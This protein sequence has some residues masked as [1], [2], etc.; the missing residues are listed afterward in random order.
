MIHRFQVQPADVCHFG[1]RMRAHE[2]GRNSWISISIVTIL[3]LSGFMPLID[4]GLAFQSD[5]SGQDPLGF[6]AST[7]GNHTSALTNGFVIPA[8][9]TITDGWMNVSNDWNSDG[10]NGTWFESGVVN[11]SLDMGKNDFTSTSHF[12]GSISLAPDRNV[13][14]VDDFEDLNLQF[15]GFTASSD[16]WMVSDLNL[17][18]ANG[19]LPNSV[20][21]GI[22]FAGATQ[23]GG[24]HPG[25]NE[26]LLIEFITLPQVINN[27]SLHFEHWLA[28]D[29]NDGAWV[30][31]RLDNGSWNNIEPINGH[32]QTLENGTPA[33]VGL[34]A[35]AWSSVEYSLEQE[36]GL[37]ELQNASSISF[38][39]HISTAQNSMERPGWFIDAINLSNTG[40]PTNS[41]FHGNLNGAYAANADGAITISANTTGM[42]SPM[43]LEFWVDWD[44]EGNNND[45]LVVEASLDGTNWSLISAPPG[46]PGSGVYID[47]VWIYSESNG[48]KQ[49]M[50]P[51]PNSFTNKS[52][53]WFR[54][55]VY[56]DGQVNGGYGISGWE[57][58]Y[59]DDPTLHSNIQAPNHQKLLLD[60]F[61]S[62]NSVS[63]FSPS[64]SVQQWQHV[65]NHGHNGPTWSAFG[66]EDSPLWPDGW[67]VKIDFG[68]RGWGFGQYPG[69]GPMTGFTSGSNGAGIEFS[70]KYLPDMWTH[71]ITPEMHIPEE[72]SARLAFQHWMCAEP[73][74]DGGTVYVSTDDG[75][76]WSHFGQNSNNFYDTNSTVN[77]NSPLY[78]KGIFDGSLVTSG[79]FNAHPFTLKKADVSHLA[80]EDVRFRFSFFSDQYVEEWGWYLDDVGIEV[81]YFETQG[82]WTSPPIYADEWGYGLL[83]IRGS[84]P[85]GTSVTASVLD[86]NEQYLFENLS[87]P[88]N[89]QNINWSAYPSIKVRLNLHTTDPYL[90]P[91]IDKISIGSNLHL[92]KNT[93]NSAWSNGSEYGYNEPANWHIRNNRWEAGGSGSSYLGY[94]FFEHR[95]IKELRLNCVC[96]GV[97]VNIGGQSQLVN[98]PTTIIQTRNA[99]MG[100]VLV[101]LIINQNGWIESF[102]MHAK[103][104]GI[105]NHSAIDIGNDGVDSDKGW[106]ENEPEWAWPNDSIYPISHYGLQSEISHVEVVKEGLSSRIDINSHS[107]SMIVE[108]STLNISSYIPNDAEVISYQFIFDAVYLG[109]DSNNSSF[110]HDWDG[111]YIGSGGG[112]NS[113]INDWNMQMFGE[114]TNF[115]IPQIIEFQEF[116]YLF[117]FTGLWKLDVH[118][119]MFTYDLKENISLDEDDLS[120]ILAEQSLIQNSTQIEIPVNYSSYGGAVSVDGAII[121]QYMITNSVIETPE[122]MVPDGSIYRTIT[123]HK[124]LRGDEFTSV[125]LMLSP[126]RSIDSAEVLMRIVN[127]QSSEPSFEQPLGQGLIDWDYSNTT[128]TQ[129]EDGWI[130]EW[131]WSTLWL[132][133]DRARLH[134]L[135]EAHDAAGT[136]LGP[137]VKTTGFSAGNAV[138]NDLELVNIVVKDRFGRVISDILDPEYP[139]PVAA[140]SNIE[141]EG[142]VRFEGSVDSWIPMGDTKIELLLVQGNF[143]NST[144]LEVG[145]EGRWQYNLNIPEAN[146]D[147]SYNIPIKLEAYLYDAGPKNIPEGLVEDTTTG[148]RGAEFIWDNGGPILGTLYAM[149]P[150]GDQPADGHIWNKNIPLALGIEISD[151]SALGDELNLHY[152]RQSLDDDDDDGNA[153][154]S[155]YNKLTI[156]L[157]K[158]VSEYIEFPFIEVGDV[159]ENSVIS[160]YVS[161]EDLAGIPVYG[162]GNY[163]L[164]ADLATII[165]MQDTPTEVV[166]F[167]LEM[168]LYDGQIIPSQ[169]HVF[170][171]AIEDSNGLNSLDSIFFSLTGNSDI[172]SIEYLPWSN[173]PI[174]W[175]EECF[176]TEPLVIVEDAHPRYSVQFNFK[177]KWSSIEQLGEEKYI[178][179]FRIE[180]LGTDLGLGLTNLVWLEWTLLTQLEVNIISLVDLVPKSGSLLENTL[181]LTP[182]DVI[183]LEWNLRYAGTNIT[184]SEL[185]EGTM[186]NAKILGGLSEM[187]AEVNL[188]NNQT[189]ITRFAFKSDDFPNHRGNLIIAI[190]GMEEY[191][192]EDLEVSV[193]LDDDSPRV[194][195]HSTSLL[196][197][198]SDSLD[199]IQVSFSIID[200]NGMKPGPLSLHWQF[201]RNGLAIT[202]AAGV[203]QVDHISGEIYNDILN[204]SEALKQVE[205]RG[206]DDLI[207]W[208]EGEDLSGNS[209]AGP[210]SKIE[211]R[212][213]VWD[214]IKFEPQVTYISVNP[215][216]P[217]LGEIITIDVQV[218]NT[219]TLEGNFSLKL[220]QLIDGELIEI[221][222]TK[223]Y[224]LLPGLSAQFTFEYEIAA[225]G[226]Q[227]LYIEIEGEDGLTPIPLGIVRDSL[228]EDNAADQQMIWA[229]GGLVI[230][231]CTFTIFML[232]R[233]QLHSENDEYDDIVW[234]DESKSGRNIVNLAS[235]KQ[236][237]SLEI[238]PPRPPELDMIHE[239]E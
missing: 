67:D 13:G 178:P 29:E 95:P 5:Y 176:Q 16:I 197:I 1:V 192:I 96:S 199:D 45:N 124:H 47:G 239:E 226:D 7:E 190:T 194:S 146:A 91:V 133:D 115:T 87:L 92:T 204:L 158:G 227:Q 86:I 33:F 109:T 8:N 38:R 98:S 110:Q 48:F 229:L 69:H 181:Y 129:T 26:W 222:T 120:I 105:A 114:R 15:R 174:I 200:D 182:G 219:G 145:E 89:L 177:L 73:N 215:R 159:L 203:L 198:R 137:A 123:K 3:L 46:I 57:G 126:Y 106:S 41:W 220:I 193:I 27:Y 157:N 77:P 223:D 52:Q 58:L 24:L 70:G 83:D 28:V 2:R 104:H 216:L 155:E 185:P 154:I 136:I 206:T 10:G 88:L 187:E 61:S 238:P 80:G 128:I 208:I 236:Q 170:A 172:C 62:N 75:S 135:A 101:S 121:W 37:N 82:N 214:Y 100:Q 39:F 68:N 228:L 189:G 117:N 112:G 186:S 4:I 184:A 148:I 166:A 201:E 132:W 81:D 42:P 144:I 19:S 63:P 119:M 165:L 149:T 143:T 23:A 205:L 196:R 78:L 209:L 111:Q 160:V 97:Y 103:Y 25:T 234:E 230:I 232:I 183:D 51:V 180:D 22:L 202:G 9:A 107:I 224:E 195:F 162:G 94:S 49:I 213:P 30:E 53:V 76:T 231:I 141:I 134:F 59:L 161:A 21:E 113:G 147:L 175:D 93:V 44:I 60:N 225:L 11:R 171:F 66:F 127:P 218:Q 151:Q 85:L 72:A 74:W 237:I 152:W 153:E 150:G 50:M 125:E 84:I 102:D 71:L 56:T 217:L 14:W 221:E 173:V 211:P 65:T 168:Q 138:E 36:I 156:Q 43:E 79:C 233:S 20:P 122:A 169:E 188:S 17:S 130:I 131:Y 167:D 12:D 18:T 179:S 118:R 235:P 40:E 99:G 35:S 212:R 31:A 55:R 210:G 54:F 163:G 207:V 32:T 108:N 34:N 116:R 6:N 139:W 142:Q 90:T 191:Q 64:G 164:D 140:G